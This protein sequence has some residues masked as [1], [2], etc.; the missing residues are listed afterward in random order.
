MNKGKDHYFIVLNLNFAPLVSY[1]TWRSDQGGDTSSY[2]LP[3]CL[4]VYHWTFVFVFY[5]MRV[6]LL[7]NPY[8]SLPGNLSIQPSNSRSVSL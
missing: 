8:T 6:C 4:A 5:V 7:L 3:L 2:I 1:P